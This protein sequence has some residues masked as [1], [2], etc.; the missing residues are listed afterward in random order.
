MDDRK[1]DRL[2]QAVL[3]GE[4]SPDEARELERVLAADPA[5]RQQC[6][7]CNAP[8]NLARGDC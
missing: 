6:T 1:L 2:M 8:K 5:E 7:R 3:D 4:A